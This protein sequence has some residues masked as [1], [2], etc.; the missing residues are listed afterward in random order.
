M[1]ADD[2]ARALDDIDESVR[3]TAPFDI[4]PRGIRFRPGPEMESQ[5][6]AVAGRGDAVVPALSGRLAD[7]DPLR[8]IVWLSLLTR[9][10]TPAAAAATDEFVERLDRED[11]WAGE[12]PGRREILLY[13]GRPN[14]A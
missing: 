3:S 12:F 9:I 8:S 7:S 6:Q 11:R 13:L 14:A 4:S 2:I 1:D 5:L 10:G